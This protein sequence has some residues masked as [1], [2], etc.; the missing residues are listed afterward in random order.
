[1]TYSVEE[2]NEFLLRREESRAHAEQHFAAALLALRDMVGYGTHLIIR[3]YN[4]SAQDYVSMVVVT[5]LLKQIVSVKG[6]A[7]LRCSR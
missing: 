5:V 6:T 2:P 4:A 3:A 1:M 7:T